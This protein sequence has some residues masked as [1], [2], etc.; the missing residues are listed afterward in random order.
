M[1]KQKK[2][3]FHSITEVKEEFLPVYIAEKKEEAKIIEKIEKKIE[4]Y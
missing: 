1:T 3:K 2:E 4:R